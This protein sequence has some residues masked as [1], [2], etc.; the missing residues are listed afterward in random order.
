[1]RVG[2]KFFGQLDPV[3]VALARPVT[4][5]QRTAFIMYIDKVR[6]GLNVSRG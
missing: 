2:P 3:G 1:M 5:L 4:F 6:A